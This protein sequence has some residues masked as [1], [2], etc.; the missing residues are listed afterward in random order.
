[1]RETKTVLFASRQR[2]RSPVSYAAILGPPSP[3]LLSS[4]L[5]IQLFYL[6]VCHLTRVLRVCHSEEKNK[7]KKRNLITPR[8][9]QATNRQNAATLT[10]LTK[11]MPSPS[12]LLMRHCLTVIEYDQTSA[13]LSVC[14]SALMGRAALGGGS[15]QAFSLA[16]TEDA[17]MQ[18]TT[19]FPGWRCCKRLSLCSAVS[20]AVLEP[21]QACAQG[22]HVDTRLQKAGVFLAINNVFYSLS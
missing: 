3:P 9:L 8:Q 19:I 10:P 7:T 22:E 13:T 6:A 2:R 4:K 15:K 21:V 5:I 1:M 17:E 16:D 11:S 20:L 14:L 18:R 12:V